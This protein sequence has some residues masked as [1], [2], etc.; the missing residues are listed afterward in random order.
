MTSRETGTTEGPFVDEGQQEMPF[1]PAPNALGG[2]QED[3][4]NDTDSSEDIQNTKY[5]D[6]TPLITPSTFIKGLLVE[7]VCLLV[8]LAF[9]VFAIMGIQSKDKEM[10]QREETLLSVAR[11]VSHAPISFLRSILLCIY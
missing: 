5:H 4:T 7:S 6:A 10:G 11:F 9:L 8:A 1:F 3:D 2:R